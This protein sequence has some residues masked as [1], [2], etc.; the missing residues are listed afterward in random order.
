[1]PV[2]SLVG[3]RVTFRWV[4]VESVATRE[5]GN[6][7]EHGSAGGDPKGSSVGEIPSY[8]APSIPRA[9]EAEPGSPSPHPTPAA[10]G[11]DCVGIG[12]GDEEQPK[13]R[14]HLSAPLV[15]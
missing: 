7:V 4:P 6:S 2:K 10:D 15:A 3:L 1:M 12:L 5:C 8:R 11:A 14:C 13:R 9:V